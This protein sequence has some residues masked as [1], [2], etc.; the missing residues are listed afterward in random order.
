M[1]RKSKKK[2]SATR[3][4]A[5]F[6]R[7]NPRL[8]VRQLLAFLRVP[9]KAVEAAV[10][11]RGP[12]SEVRGVGKI[13]IKKV[14]AARALEML[15]RLYKTVERHA[16]T[17]GAR[18]KPSGRRKLAANR[19]RMD[20]LCEQMAPLVKALPRGLAGTILADALWGSPSDSLEFLRSL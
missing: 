6:K 11:A 2:K 12:L 19:A 9:K 17:G 18:L 7:P 10:A 8:S 5:Q 3:S 4:R 13:T 20:G 15:A 14:E 16:P 1:C